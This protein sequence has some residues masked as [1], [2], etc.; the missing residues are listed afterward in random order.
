MILK[1]MTSNSSGPAPVFAPLAYSLSRRNALF[2]PLL[3]ALSAPLIAHAQSSTD[4]KTLDS[5]KVTAERRDGYIARPSATGTG[6]TLS[7]LETPQS[8]STLTRQEL[9]DFGLNNADTALALATGV[10]VEL[11]ET[12]RTYYTARGFDILNF[13]VDG[14]GMPFTN[15]GSEGDIDTA[16]YERIEVLRGANGLM[17]STGYPSATV[18]FVRKRPTE[19]FQGSVKVGGGSWSN[20]R[21]DLD[22]SGKLNRAGTVRGRA[23][24]AWQDGDSYLDRYSKKKTMLYGIVE[25]DLSDSTLLTLG[26]SYQKNQPRGGMWGALPLYYTDGTATN[27]ARSTNSAADW[28]YWNSTDKRVFLELE[29]K[30]GSDWTLKASLNYRKFDTDG[31]L[32]YVYGTPVKGTSEGLYSYPSAYHSSEDQKY[33]S[34]QASGTFAFLGRDHD[35]TVGVRWEKT[36]VDQLS[37]YSSDTGTSI[38]SLQ[39]WTGAYPK[40]NFDSSS[41]GANFDIT[42]KSAYASV[43]W[44]LTDR[45]KLI[46]GLNHTWIESSGQTYGVIHDY[47]ASKSS[48]FVGA[49]YNFAPNYALYGSYAEIFNPQYV[50]DAS[51]HLLEPVTGDNAEMGIK[52]Q[53]LEGRINGSLAIFRAKENHL[54]SDATYSTSIGGYYY[55]PVN[56]TSTGFEADIAGQVSQD[57]QLSAGYTQLSLKDDE[58]DNTLTYVPR[59]TF[60]LAAT[61]RIPQWEQLKVGATV[62][63]QD[64]IWRDQDV[65]STSGT[66]IITRQGSYALLGLMTSYDFT[67][68]ITASFNLNNVTD[69]KYINSLYWD[70]GYYGAGRNWWLSVSYRF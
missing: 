48:P 16:I 42:R 38:G 39:D 18:N 9:D 25:A 3:A 45:L 59:R 56:A 47:D 7:P 17:S 31:D 69:R 32:F 27:Y 44:N 57:L 37:W 15:G 50:V 61:Y 65:T 53:W 26:A 51:N 43:R 58:G 34:L 22:V 60:K 35:A 36:E 10:N 46:T 33:G 19:D 12:D 2:L 28:T 23:V 6:L 5:V 24:A 49:V 8:T 52:G 62:R 29:Q 63:W 70:Q 54:A 68:K 13:Q 40:P 64:R 4:A 1:A 30:L 66:E 11:V 55:T 14:L 20:R 67:P 41:S 21:V